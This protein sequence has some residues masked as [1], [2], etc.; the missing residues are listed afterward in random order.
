MP[1]SRRVSFSTGKPRCS[2]TAS[3]SSM[4]FSARAARATAASSTRAKGSTASTEVQVAPLR[5]PR[6]Q[7]VMVR[8]AF[9]S[10]LNTT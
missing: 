3:P 8:I 1:T 10:A 9:S 6:V 2:A 4:P 5:L 7:K